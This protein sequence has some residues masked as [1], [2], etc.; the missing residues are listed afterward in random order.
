MHVS[1]GFCKAWQSGVEGR[2][3]VDPV[4]EGRNRGFWFIFGKGGNW[5]P[6]M[7]V[8]ECLQQHQLSALAKQGTCL[9]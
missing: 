7:R 3:N 8:A 1:A 2:G 9:N 5:S 4:E 6:W